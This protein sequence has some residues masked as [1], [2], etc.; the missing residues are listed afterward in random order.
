MW[1]LSV[2]IDA[3]RRFWHI[4]TVLVCWRYQVTIFI[5]LYDQAKF[6]LVVW[7]MNFIFSIYWEYLGIIIIPA[8]ELIFFRGVG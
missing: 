1:E 3:A 7:N 5:V 2:A 6:W 4:S 8:D